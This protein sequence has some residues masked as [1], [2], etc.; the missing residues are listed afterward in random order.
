MLSV[1]FKHRKHEWCTHGTCACANG[2]IKD[3]LDYFNTAIMLYNKYDY[4]YILSQAGIHQS[5]TKL[6]NVSALLGVNL[7]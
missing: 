2:A 7:S 1:N 5:N 6:Y 3:E 4:G